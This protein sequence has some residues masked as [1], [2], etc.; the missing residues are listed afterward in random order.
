MLQS[1]HGDIRLTSANERSD[2][3]LLASSLDLVGAQLLKH[4]PAGVVE[5]QLAHAVLAAVPV[6]VVGVADFFD[7]LAEPEVDNAAVRA[8]FAPVLAETFHHFSRQHG[9]SPVGADF[10]GA[11]A[12]ALDFD[13]GGDR[14]ERVHLAPGGVVALHGACLWGAA[15]SRAVGE[16]GLWVDDQVAGVDHASAGN[17]DSAD[18]EVATARA[19]EVVFN[20][21]FAERVD[22]WRCDTRHHHLAIQVDWDLVV[23]SGLCC[24]AI[25]SECN[26]LE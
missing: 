11:G 19:A 3:V 26:H 4:L 20:E 22:E 9:V 15:A 24:F 7:E 8:V 13:G 6:A 21:Q 25:S 5:S 2:A 12:E 16:L 17:E 18:G 10:E 1:T 23:G 14:A